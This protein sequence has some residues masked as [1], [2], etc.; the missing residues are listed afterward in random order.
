MLPDVRF[1]LNSDDL[2]A[3]LIFHGGAENRPKTKGYEAS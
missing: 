1:T 2:L 3:A